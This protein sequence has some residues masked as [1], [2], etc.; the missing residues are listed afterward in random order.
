MK[1][2][3]FLLLIALFLSGSVFGQQDEG[4]SEKMEFISTFF[5]KN[6]TE[7]HIRSRTQC[8]LS[9]IY[10][11][12]ENNHIHSVDSLT[13]TFQNIL[14]TFEETG[15]LDTIYRLD[16][17]DNSGEYQ[18]E[19]RILEYHFVYN[20]EG[21]GNNSTDKPLGG[22]DDYEKST[23]CINADFES[24][25][26]NNWTLA[27]GTNGPGSISPGTNNPGMN[28]LTG[29]HVIMG[30]GSGT[31]AKTNNNVPRVFPGGGTYSLRLGDQGTNWNAARAT[32]TFVITPQT[33]LFLYRYAVVLEDPGHTA[34]EQPFLQINLTISGDNEACG[35]YYQAASGSAPG[36]QTAGGFGSTVRYK[37]WETVS[38][39]LSPYMGQTATVSF[40]TSDCSQGGHFGYAYID[41]ECRPMPSLADATLSCLNPT[42]T[43][44]GPPG[45]MGYAWTGPGI[46][47]A[48]NQQNVNVNEPGTYQVTVIPVQGPQCSYTLDVLVEEDIGGVDADFDIIPDMVCLGTPIDFTNTSTSTGATGPITNLDWSFGDGNTGSGENVTHVYTTPGVYTVTLDVLTDLNCDGTI[49]K[50]VTVLPMPEANFTITPA[51]VTDALTFQDQST[52]DTNFP[53]VITSWDWDFGDGSTGTGQ[54]PSHQYD[55][56]GVY[57][58]T[59]TIETNNGCVHS[60]T[61]PAEVYPNP[62]P[63]Y[64]AISVCLNDGTVFTDQTTVSNANTTNTIV[65]WSWDFTDGN[66]STDQN[67]DNVFPSEGIFNPTLTVVTDKG[68]TGTYTGEITVYPNP[69]ADFSATKVCLLTSSEF[70][71]ESSVSNAY[72][73]NE[74]T[75]WSWDFDD[76]SSASTQNPEH[77]FGT[78]GYFDVTLTVTTEHGCTNST[79]EEV[80]VYSNP[81]ADFETDSI[82]EGTLTNF[83]DLSSAAPTNSD[84][85]MGWSWDFTDG[86]TSTTQSPTHLFDDE[87]IYNVT[88]EVQSDKGCFNEITKPVLVYPNPVVSFTPT[89]VCLDSPTEFTDNSTISNS[90][91]SNQNVAWVW[92]FGEVGASNTTQNAAHTYS[93]EGFYDASLTV[94]SDKG[95]VTTENVEITVYP[96]PVVAFSPTEVCLEAPTIFNDQSTVSNTYTENEIVDWS[97]NF[98]DGSTSTDQNPEH[99]YT[100]EGIYDGVLT[101]TTDHGCQSIDTIAVTVFPNPVADFS[102]DSVCQGVASSFQDLSEVN[103][104]NGDFVNQW[105]WDF[106]DGQSATVQNPVHTYSAESIYDVTLTVKTNNGCFDDI[107]KVTEIYPNP[108]VEFSATDV[109]LNFTNEFTDESTVSNQ[110]TSNQIVDWNW[111]FYDGI[112]SSDQ[113]PTH[114]YINDGTYFVNLTVTTNNNCTTSG[115]MPVHVYPEPIAGFTGI[116]LEG[117]SPIC[118]IVTS[119]THVN[120]PSSIVNYVWTLSDGTVYEGSSPILTDCFEDEPGIDITYGLHLL[121][122]T[123]QGCID[124]YN[125]DDY[126]HVYHNPV[127][128]FI[129]SPDELNVMDPTTEL[130]N[131]SLYA[132]SYLWN[133]EGQGT[134]DLF[135]PGETTF[136]YE[137][138]VH[139]VWLTAYTDKGCVDSIQKVIE[140]L[141]KLIFFVPNTFTPDQDDFNEVFRPIFSNGVD[142]EGYTLLIFNRWGELIFESHNMD[143]GWK[144]TYGADSP[145]IVKDG[146]YVWKMEFREAWSDKKHNYMG[147][148]NVI[149]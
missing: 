82:C 49:S 98:S 144:G 10:D 36:Y 124:E 43:L 56:E 27:W 81:V 38:I 122:T 13:H 32:Y 110:H 114:D 139:N 45:A 64:S 3:I 25:D 133:I 138:G 57:D 97:W 7:E 53:D 111:D 116:D 71:D 29:N 84:Y 119:T 146:T 94:T 104:A 16:P 8:E 18:R 128:D 68:C 62:D 125:E 66:M 72:T 80:T 147:H 48:N 135:E 39:S 143:V 83:T 107:T 6:Q 132:D 11:Q 23:E 55:T 63:D 79:T 89:E 118:P 102:I 67:P 95:C 134:S 34:S 90:H 47:G 76:G 101:V 22:E 24:G 129:F 41:A 74:V 40:L 61:L 141:D 4:I 58:V 37:N 51:C 78:D 44:T 70:T 142:P 123:E 105:A 65:D 92:D 145:R 117:C 2:Y 46:V 14:N 54:N 59:L 69:V 15:M 130:T 19:Q 33:E 88:L 136:P 50:Q 73:T 131:T 93:S 115:T 17:L 60:L 121:V 85:L 9:L 100:T 137:A 127:A 112:S 75:N 140:V 5:Q 52:V 87:N 1:H 120:S 77:T 99:T 20:Q 113:N 42:Q 12:Y 149:R 21:A 106:G 109:C 26:F 103:N 28:S 126:I 30:P 91:T 86:N 31:D 35:Y 108:V 148:V 96:N